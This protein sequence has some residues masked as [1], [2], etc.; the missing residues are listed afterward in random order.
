MIATGS[1]MMNEDFCK[2][3]ALSAL[4]YGVLAFACILTAT[5]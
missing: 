1:K 5:I 4:L 3:L 2:G